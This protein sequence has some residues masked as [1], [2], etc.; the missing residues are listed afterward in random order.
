MTYTFSSITSG[1]VNLS[2]NLLDGYLNISVYLIVP[3][4]FQ[5]F[6]CLLH[7]STCVHEFPKQL[8]HV[9][10]N[11][12]KS[13]NQATVSTDSIIVYFMLAVF[14]DAIA[15]CVCLYTIGHP[16]AVPECRDGVTHG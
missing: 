2:H 14:P 12:L 9:W 3:H 8:K 11:S 5:C 15:C 7:V 13:L 16:S 6:A 1:L 4:W 10:L